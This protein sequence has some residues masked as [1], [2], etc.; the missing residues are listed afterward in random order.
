MRHIQLVPSFPIVLALCC[1][2]LAQADSPAYVLDF[3]KTAIQ[4]KSLGIPGFSVSSSAMPRVYSLGITTTI[5]RENI[6]DEPRNS[7]TVLFKITNNGRN[8][9]SIPI[10]L[11][12][13]EVHK[14]ASL[15]RR[16]AIFGAEFSG[17]TQP[18]REVLAVAFSSDSMKDCSVQLDPGR[19]VLAKA[20]LILPPSPKKTMPIELRGFVYEYKLKDGDFIIAQKSEE[21]KSENSLTI[22]H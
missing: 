7:L 21:V 19:Y 14:K 6:P 1:L 5:Q 22:S 8:A 11:D 16:T 20:R 2:S 18:R 12:Q 3:T 15:N 13:T 10:C 9:V 17:E 4:S